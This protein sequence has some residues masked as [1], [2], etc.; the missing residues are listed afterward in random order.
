M[1]AILDMNNNLKIALNKKDYTEL[2]KLV[3]EL[4][5]NKDIYEKHNDPDYE[6]LRQTFT[7]IVIWTTQVKYKL[8]RLIFAY[9]N[10]TAKD[11]EK[12]RKDVTDIINDIESM[13]D[14]DTLPDSIAARLKSIKSK[15]S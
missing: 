10:L 5:D 9:R 15:L 11:T 6:Q 4:R 13:V 12:N 3:H 14:I 1:S 8:A 7:R 2:D